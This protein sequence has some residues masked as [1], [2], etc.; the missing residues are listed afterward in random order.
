MST[1]HASAA[2]AIATKIV[3]G[4]LAARLAR[5]EGNIS[6]RRPQDII[7]GLTVACVSTASRIEITA[8]GD[9][10]EAALR[11]DAQRIIREMFGLRID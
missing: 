6:R 10:D 9:I 2:E 1:P 5:L 4:H 7:D 11:A 3:L 8:D